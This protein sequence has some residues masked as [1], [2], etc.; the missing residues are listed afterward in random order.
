MTYLTPTH[1]YVP[2][3]SERHPEDAFAA[4]CATAAPDMTAEDLAACDAFKHG[5]HYLEQGFF[6]EAHEVLEPVW[7]VLPDGDPRRFTQGL[8]QLANAL[9]KARMDRPK[10]ALRLCAMARDL[11]AGP[12]DT[13]MGVSRKTYLG[14]IDQTENR[15]KSAKP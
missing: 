2:G 11:L 15:L 7:M 8:I 13:V 1:A 5:L 3:E 12:S 9:L 6:W 14:L 4:V 10:A